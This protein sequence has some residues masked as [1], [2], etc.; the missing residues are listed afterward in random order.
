MTGLH[1]GSHNPQ[2]PGYSNQQINHSV[3]TGVVYDTAV[4]SSQTAFAA[5]SEVWEVKK[6][7]FC[8]G[9]QQV[10]TATREGLLCTHLTGIACSWPG[11]VSGKVLLE[12]KMIRQW[13]H[14]Y[15]TT[16]ESGS[17]QWLVSVG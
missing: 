13:K 2:I 10:P 7:C 11:E 12:L 5:E 6:K 17:P 4:T 15:W 9:G 14:R 16:W 8:E 1:E 3:L